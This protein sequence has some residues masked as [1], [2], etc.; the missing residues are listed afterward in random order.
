MS[1][2]DIFNYYE[3]FKKEEIKTVALLTAEVL[4]NKLVL[5]VKEMSQI[6]MD[7]RAKERQE[8]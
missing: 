2:Q 8:L 5:E 1:L 6:E 4:I 3:R 7:R